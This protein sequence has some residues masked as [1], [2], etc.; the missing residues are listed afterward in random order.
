VRGDGETQKLF[1]GKG[2]GTSQS[3][4]GLSQV[5]KP[6]LLKGNPPPGNNG[7]GSK[8]NGERLFGLISKGEIEEDGIRPII[9][10][11]GEEELFHPGE[12][13]F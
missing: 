11:T 9:I 4:D 13:D 5:V 7:Y 3:V 12:R 1:A 2:G 10:V 8:P 6:F